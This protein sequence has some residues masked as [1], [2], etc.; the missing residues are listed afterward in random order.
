MLSDL[1]VSFVYA[2]PTATA[3]TKLRLR[4]QPVE[5]WRRL[6]KM[7]QPTSASTRR[8]L[9]LPLCLEHFLRLEKPWHLHLF[10]APAQYHN[11]SP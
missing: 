8:L 4:D 1:P 3:I 5:V 10:R 11:I 9:A 6:M 2:Q 7:T